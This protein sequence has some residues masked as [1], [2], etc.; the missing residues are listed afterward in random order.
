MSNN[1]FVIR[2]TR[3]QVAKQGLLRVPRGEYRGDWK[4]KVTPLDLFVLNLELE[5]LFDNYTSN[6]EITQNSENKNHLDNDDIYI[7]RASRLGD[8]RDLTVEVSCAFRDPY[9]V[10]TVKKISGNEHTFK[11]ICSIINYKITGEEFE[12]IPERNE[13]TNT[14][15]SEKCIICVSKEDAEDK[16]LLQSTTPMYGHRSITWAK[17]ASTLGIF[18]YNVNLDM[19]FINYTSGVD[20]EEGDKDYHNL[21]NH[22]T[23]TLTA[24]IPWNKHDLKVKVTC[25]Y[26]EPNFVITVTR[27][28]GNKNVFINLCKRVRSYVF[29]E[30]YNRRNDLHV[31]N[32]QDGGRR[33]RKTHR[34][35]LH[36][37]KS[38]RS[39]H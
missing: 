21:E 36:R 33:R 14:I 3:E 32:E 29:G 16:N 15:T 5:A 1:E 24:E 2:A 39:R 25:E 28:E 20:T 13:C 23:Y 18:V 30:I 11:N 35:K 27:V 31:N 26:H 19:F 7:I 9:F 10:V 4:E 22:D 12:R 34:R 37:N 38:R 8:T 6:V 17:S